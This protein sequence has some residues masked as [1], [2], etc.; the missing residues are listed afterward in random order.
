M[1]GLHLSVNPKTQRTL[2]GVSGFTR[3][4][5]AATLRRSGKGPCHLEEK[6]IRFRVEAL[7]FKT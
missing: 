6:Q 1:S 4:L 2:R 3:P 7:G 5:R